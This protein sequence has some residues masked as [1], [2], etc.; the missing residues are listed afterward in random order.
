MLGNN[1]HVENSIGDTGAHYLANALQQNKV[2]HFEYSLLCSSSLSFSK[3]LTM[4]NLSSNK[5][6]DVGVQHLTDALQNNKVTHR[7]KE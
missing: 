7:F 4:L 5:I 6:G 2:K 1:Q 3:T